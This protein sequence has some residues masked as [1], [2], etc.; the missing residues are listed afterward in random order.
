VKGKLVLAAAGILLALGVM[1]WAEG[2]SADQPTP[3]YYMALGDS[4]AAGQGPA[5]LSALG[6]WVYSDA[7][8]ALTT[9]ERSVFPIWQPMVRPVSP[10]LGIKWRALLKPSMTLTRRYK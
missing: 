4:L 1:A 8:T 10:F 2:V 9:T 5:S 6:M 7:S 3:D